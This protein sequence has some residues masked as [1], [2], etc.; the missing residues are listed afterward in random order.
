MLNKKICVYFLLQ[1]VIQVEVIL[2]DTNHTKQDIIINEDLVRRN[3]AEFIN[4][5]SVKPKIV[6]H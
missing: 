2:F 4:M 3:L 1:D 6:K 5:V